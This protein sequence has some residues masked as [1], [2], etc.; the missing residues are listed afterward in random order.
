MKT[1][2]AFLCLAALAGCGSA[3]QEPLIKSMTPQKVGGP[4]EGCEAI[5][6]SPVPFAQL[7]WQDSL[8]DFTEAGP[9]LVVSG[10]V[11]KKDGR[12][13]AADVVIYAYHTDQKGL[14]SKKGG[15]EGWARRHGYIRG[16]VKTDA[17]GRYRF[18]T[19]RPAAYPNS[20]I[21]AHIHLTIK[22]PSLNEYYIDDILFDDDPLLT[23]GARSRQTNR[24]GDGIVRP[25][26]RD[27][28]AYAERNIYLGQN[29]D[30]YPK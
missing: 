24:G 6:E 22:E 23:K 29:I 4:C 10:K 20:D 2:F 21:A 30:N 9:K 18:F 7:S 8:P 27:G 28:I 12:T 19:L 1:L 3:P 15:E 26:I 11:F 25:G 14:Y 5:Y 16:W 13:P 17:Q